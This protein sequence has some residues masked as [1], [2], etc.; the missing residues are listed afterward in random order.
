MCVRGPYTEAEILR[1]LV[2]AH[3]VHGVLEELLSS[4]DEVRNA[5]A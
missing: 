2:N 1:R 5:V 3:V 4:P